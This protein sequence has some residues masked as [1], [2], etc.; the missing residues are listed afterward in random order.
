M[1]ATSGR[2]R[3]PHRD[4]RRRRRFGLV[5]YQVL[6]PGSGFFGQ[7][8]SGLERLGLRG[9]SNISLVTRVSVGLHLLSLSKTWYNTLYCR[10]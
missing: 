10:E 1:R 8:R 4:S 6:I 5:L 9:Q 7:G 3:I 2:G